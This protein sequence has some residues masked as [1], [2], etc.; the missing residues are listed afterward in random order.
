MI[1]DFGFCCFTNFLFKTF[2][3]VRPLTD[4]FLISWT[5]PDWRGIIFLIYL[6]V[7]QA[8]TGPVGISDLW[9]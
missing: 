4:D 2:R 5:L 8:G 6:F 7:G 9:F 1:L 3:T